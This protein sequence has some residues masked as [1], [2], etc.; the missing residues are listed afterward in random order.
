MDRSQTSIRSPSAPRT[1][2]PDHERER[3]RARGSRSLS[4]ISK[5]IAQDRRETELD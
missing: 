3:T 1:R 4:R 2:G 5:C